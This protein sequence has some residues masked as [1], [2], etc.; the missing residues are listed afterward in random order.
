VG[1]A[2]LALLATFSY[3]MVAMIYYALPRILHREMYSKSLMEWHYWLSL[4]GFLV[5][6]VA[7]TIVGLVQSAQWAAGIPIQKVVL[8]LF[9][10]WVFRAFGGILM[11]A[12]QAV[13]AYNVYRTVAAPAPQPKPATA[14]A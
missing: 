4:I 7:L 6:F 11:L 10:H 12:G 14:A 5:F 3:W 2:H 13:F 8:D 9:P 1:H